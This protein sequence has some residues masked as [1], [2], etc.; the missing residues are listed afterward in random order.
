MNSVG[1]PNG[2]VSQSG[3]AGCKVRHG[4]TNC[5]WCGDKTPT[6]DDEQDYGSPQCRHE[7]AWARANGRLPAP[8]G[9]DPEGVALLLEAFWLQRA[10]CLKRHHRAELEW[11]LSEQFVA[12]CDLDGHGLIAQRRERFLGMWEVRWGDEDLLQRAPCR[13]C[14]TADHRDFWHGETERPY[15]KAC[16]KAQK[17]ARREKKA[18]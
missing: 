14:G 16:E 13:T 12:W 8:K 18:A 6:G 4:K 2:Q 9:C 10:D 5:A 1:N 15:C 7:V 11:L 17:R 3:N